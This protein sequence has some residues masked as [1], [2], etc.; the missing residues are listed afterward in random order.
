MID[1]WDVQV[2]GV[3]MWDEDVAS[4]VPIEIL[5]LMIAVKWS[6]EKSED[7]YKKRLGGILV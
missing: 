5:P 1:H 6:D 7:V 2:K 3:V 4:R